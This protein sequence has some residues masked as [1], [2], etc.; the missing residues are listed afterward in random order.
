M[1]RSLAAL[2]AGT[3]VLAAAVP[4]SAVTTVTTA[5]GAN[6]QI[7]DVAPP[8]LDTGSIRAITDNAFYGFGGIRVRVSDI[9]AS[10]PTARFNGELMRGFGLAFDGDE[11]FTT[12]QAVPLGG[13]E[14]SRAVKV[15]QGRQLVALAGHV[16]QHDGRADHGQGRLRRQR[17]P[18]LGRN[19]SAMVNSSSG[20]ATVNADD[21]WAEVATPSGA[22]GVGA[23]AG[24]RAVVGGA[25]SRA[26]A[27]SS[28]TRSATRC[29]R[30][31]SRPTSRLRQHA[32]ARARADEVAPALRRRGPRRGGRDGRPA[33]RPRSR[34]RAS[35]WRPRRTSPGSPRASLHGRQ[36][37]AAVRRSDLRGTPAPGVTP[38]PRRSSAGHD[39]RLR[40]G[41]QDDHAD[42]RRHGVRP[43]DLAGDHARLPGPDRGLRPGPVR[44]PRLH[45]RRLRRDG[46]GQGRRRRRARRARRAPC[47]ASRS[48]SRTSTTPR[49]CRP[50]TAASRSRAAARSATRSR[51]PSCARRAR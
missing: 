32:D 28:A 35:R 26:P 48:R 20:D 49:T 1:K 42:A 24:R 40:R 29:R 21:A 14:I 8:K 39:L 46:A 19:Q 10:D 47:S 43:D 15:S 45:H 16:R 18:E 3:A 37:R 34:R 33:G 22:T 36:L 2:V 5:N 31:A 27:T 25:Q 12:T 13:V 30:R 4:A 51:S 23:T 9:P 11:P 7:H 38:E 41:R 50:P 44:L 17:G 6:W